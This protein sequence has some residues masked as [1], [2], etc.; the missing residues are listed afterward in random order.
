[1]QRQRLKS[2][3]S[4]LSNCPGLAAILV[5]LLPQYLF[6]AIMRPRNHHCQSRSNTAKRS[7]TQ[8]YFVPPLSEQLANT[9][10]NWQ[11]SR[12][13]GTLQPARC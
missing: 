10:G 11:V 7:A 5:R 3:A 6:Q 2:A 12:V 4:W 13:G 8:A 9:K 1:M